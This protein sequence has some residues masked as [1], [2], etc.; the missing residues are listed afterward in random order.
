[1]LV[2]GI[3]ILH[4]LAVYQIMRLEDQ[5]PQCLMKQFIIATALEK[6]LLFL[7]EIH[8]RGKYLLSAEQM[9]GSTCK[10]LMM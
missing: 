2:C 8:Q 10:L 4:H 1:M 3:R 6:F 7:E 9:F 5:K